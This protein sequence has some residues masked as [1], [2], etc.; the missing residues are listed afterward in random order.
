[1]EIGIEFRLQPVRP[2]LPL[3]IVDVVAP[4]FSCFQVRLRP[5]HSSTATRFSLEYHI[6]MAFAVCP[7]PV[8]IHVVRQLFGPVPELFRIDTAGGVMRSLLSNLFD[9]SSA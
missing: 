9:G 2:F 3:Q 1:R 8:E 7:S 4:A 6:K 5:S